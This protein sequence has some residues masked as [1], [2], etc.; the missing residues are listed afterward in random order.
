MKNDNKKAEA[1]SRSTK[2]WPKIAQHC[3]GFGLCGFLLVLMFASVSLNYGTEHNEGSS[4]HS[5]LFV[6]FITFASGMSLFFGSISG[7]MKS[8]AQ[9][10]TL[11][12][13]AFRRVRVI[14][15]LLFG[16]IAEVYFD[17][18]LKLFLPAEARSIT[19]LNGFLAVVLGGLAYVT[20]AVTLRMRMIAR[21]KASPPS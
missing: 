9:Q 19:P 21:A 13:Y 11:L 17:R 4:L 1:G 16:M 15:P 8:N 18:Y 12:E 5:F 20:L 2:S 6:S 7:V 3:L 14:F 10:P